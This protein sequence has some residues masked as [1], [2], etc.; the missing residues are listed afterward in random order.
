MCNNFQQ[1][2]C[3]SAL[4]KIFSH[5]P[6]RSKK[7]LLQLLA[8]VTLAG[9]GHVADARTALPDVPSN[10]CIISQDM[11]LPPDNRAALPRRDDCAFLERAEKMFLWVTSPDGQGS[12]V[13]RSPAFFDAWSTDSG[14][15]ELKP[16]NFNFTTSNLKNLDVK[17][18]IDPGE[19]DG[20]VLVTQDCRLVYY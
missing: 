2:A 4:A 7:R 17:V 19:V 1:I 14:L 13:F 9:C 20:K 6:S 3:G 18:A 16:T 11:E 12:Y 8:I 15:R 10:F 5:K